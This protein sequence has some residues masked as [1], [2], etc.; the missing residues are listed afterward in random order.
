VAEREDRDGK[1]EQPTA[2]RLERAR[3]E[4]TV[5]RAHGAAAAGVVMAGAIALSWGGALFLNRLELSLRLGLSADPAAVRDRAR[6]LAAA[7]PIVAP[8]LKAI[9]A[10]AVVLIAAALFANLAVG[11]WIF[12]AQPLVPDPSRISPIAGLRRLLSRDAG[13]EM[14][15]ALVK[16]VAIA[17]IAAWLIRSWAPAFVLLAAESWPHALQHAAVLWTWMFL[18]LAAGLAGISVLEIP[19][20]L[21][22]HRNRL[23]MTRQELR[24]E[25][26]DLE[27]SPQTKRRIKTLRLRFAR[28]RMMAEVPRADVVV[29]NPEHYAA[30]LRYREGEMRA[31]RLVAKGT[32]LVA[33]R[34]R[35]IA[36]DHGVPIIEAARLARAICRFVELED[37]IPTSLYPPVAEVLAYV[38]RLRL[39]RETGAPPPPLP[40]DGRFEAPGE[41]AV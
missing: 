18:S 5:V 17:A 23:K 8:G 9:L 3:D 32:G 6:L 10:L 26:R 39:A 28:M 16:F 2:R 11:G 35:E 30:A 38:Y 31:P 33:L 34:I 25:L 20:E 22:S 24:D 27:G 1:T 15:K 14:L 12:S 7:G 37:E 21:W 41:F 13:A 29:V 36:R 19:Y 4:G 40:Q